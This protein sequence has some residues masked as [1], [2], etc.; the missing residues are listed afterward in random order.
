MVGN[1]TWAQMSTSFTRCPQS[2]GG[3]LSFC[4]IAFT[5][6]SINRTAPHSNSFARNRYHRSRCGPPVA[7]ALSFPQHLRLRHLLLLYVPAARNAAD[8][9]SLRSIAV[10]ALIL[11]SF[12]SAGV[13]SR[14]TVARQPSNHGVSNH[15]S[16]CRC[17]ARIPLLRRFDLC[18]GTRRSVPADQRPFRAHNISSALR[19]SCLYACYMARAPPIPCFPRGLSVLI[20]FCDSASRTL[21]APA[22]VLDISKFCASATCPRVRLIA[23]LSTKVFSPHCYFL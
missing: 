14:Q 6:S 12:V 11:G 13:S 3:I 4:Q 10:R 20:C 19:H 16:N 8:I 23:T 9:P 7:Q 22:L 2:V 21:C 1:K 18:A 15:L 5:L 17:G